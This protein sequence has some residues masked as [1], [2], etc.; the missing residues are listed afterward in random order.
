MFKTSGF[1]FKHP[2][3]H[4]GQSYVSIRYWHS[5]G[6]FLYINIPV[7]PL[8]SKYRFVPLHFLDTVAQKFET[9]KQ[10]LH[11]LWLPIKTLQDVQNLAK[12]GVYVP[13]IRIL[14]ITWWYLSLIFLLIS[15]LINR[16]CLHQFLG[17]KTTE[18]NKS[19]K[20]GA[21]GAYY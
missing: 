12:S 15:N 8:W 10:R 13:S 14:D 1:A 6:Y 9:N 17:T 3:L 2:V 7:P 16:L 20:T 5:I 4:P 19:L 21:N 18:A 11:L